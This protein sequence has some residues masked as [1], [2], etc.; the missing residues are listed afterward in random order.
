VSVAKSLSTGDVHVWR[1]ALDEE[2]APPCWNV[3]S[4]DEQARALRFRFEHDR[5]AFVMAHGALRT[6]LAA[7]T[8]SNAAELQF[9][10]GP[11]GKPAIDAAAHDARLEFNLSHSGGFALIAIANDRAVGIDIMKWDPNVD[12]AAVAERSFSPLERETLRALARTASNSA[13]I[14]EAFYSAWSRKEAYLKA[15]GVGLTRSPDTFDVSIAPSEP[16]ALVADHQD[17]DAS[18][19]WAMVSIDAAA[20]YSA[21]LVVARPVGDITVFD[22][23]TSLAS[24]SFHA[25]QAST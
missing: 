18:E 25:P 6:I 24:A 16:A 10:L 8:G 15:L 1:V 12:H 9:V 19:R 7:Y 21:A 2:R 22:A 13:P 20:G 3:L 4:A 11:F 5:A 23:P 14:T 17:R